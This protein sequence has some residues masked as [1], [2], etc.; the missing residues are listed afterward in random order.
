MEVRHLGSRVLVQQSVQDH[1]GVPGHFPP[2]QIWL[3]F[4][5]HLLTNPLRSKTLHLSISAALFAGQSSPQKEENNPGERRCVGRG[6]V[7]ERELV[8]EE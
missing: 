3:S 7:G 2:G 1:S 4:H 6:G 8:L 5:F